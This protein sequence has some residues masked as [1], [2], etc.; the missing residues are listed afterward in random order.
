MLAG[1]AAAVTVGAGVA[2]APVTAGA[3][4][5]GSTKGTSSDYVVLYA[6]GV[7]TSAAKVAIARAGGTITSTNDDIGYAV[8]TSTDATFEDR[9]AREKVLDG[10]AR[11]QPIGYAPSGL[12]SR[13]AVERPAAGSSRAT[14][15]TK[16]VTGARPDLEPLGNRQWDMRQ[17]GAT[18]SGS[19]RVNPGSRQVLVGIM[20]T[21]LD[22]SHPDVRP[23]MNIRLSR[24]FTKD[25]P[26][27][28]GPCE[29]A[30]CKDPATV[31]G[32]G[33]GTHVGST[34]AAPINH[35]GIA[36]V[37][38]NVTLVN[39]R[40]GHDSGYFFLDST[41]KAM[42][43][44]GDT[45]IDVVNMSF[46]TDPWLFNCTNNPADSP[47]EQREQRVIRRA[48]QRA[49]NYAMA[50]G[51]T[52]IAAAGNDLTNLNHPTVDETSPDFPPGSE[53]HRDIDNSC[54]TVPTETN[55]VIPVSAT[56]FST[57]KAWYSNWGTEQ[58]EVAAP[59]GDAY[60]SPDNTRDDRL[61]VLAAYPKH[62]AIEAGLVDTHCKAL[63]TIAVTQRYNGKC[64]TYA[65]LNGTSMASPHAVGVAA[66][67][68]SRHGH[69]DAVHGGLTLAPSQTR[70]YLLATAVPH[71]CPSPRRQ[72]YQLRDV[73][74]TFLAHYSAY[75]A[76]GVDFNAFY[77]YGI[78]NAFNAV[79]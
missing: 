70:H 24:N 35:V 21:G 56:G 43:Y 63:S 14:G 20:D 60:D 66:L 17:I 65:Y 72:Q 53:K 3:A 12:P 48:T 9:V 77:G 37:A 15:A 47:A 18:P 59:G 32:N 13:G 31:D 75:C 39:I 52:M 45:G 11:N 10:A 26:S 38:P 67:V 62:L 50:R 8:V 54:I 78:V 76:G 22:A 69:H 28:D 44:A 6:D 29:Y 58:I 2:V 40:A 1:A 79:R 4:Q 16:A 74:G 64:V 71:A 25:I 23:N 68:V 49:V 55:G 27:I 46:Y 19:Y 33:H 61:R 51:V 30:N 41:L 7:A 42:T 73:D 5:H 36:G 57:R 34:V